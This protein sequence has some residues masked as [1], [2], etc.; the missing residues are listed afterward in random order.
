MSED[1]S[2]QQPA[3]HEIPSTPTKK[4]K[5]KGARRRV[6]SVKIHIQSTYN[7]TLVSV[8]DPAGNVI[9]WSSA[10]RIGYK[11]A[12]KATPYVANEVIRDLVKRLE[13]Y[14]V[15]EAAV[16]VKG[17]GSAREAAIRAVAAHGG[18]GLTTIRDVTPI[19]HNG[20]RPRKRRRV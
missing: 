4:V 8:T 12:R 5:K 2:T 10:G 14:E 17:I 6:P 3:A 15:K 11:G 9:V 19:P 16:E 18:F 7:N 20:V 1:S 13:P